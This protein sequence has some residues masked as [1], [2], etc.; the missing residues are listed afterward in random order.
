MGDVLGGGGETETERKRE[1]NPYGETEKERM[2]MK[3]QKDHKT[4]QLLCGVFIQR[5]WKSPPKG[6]SVSLCSCN[7]FHDSQGTGGTQGSTDGRAV[8]D[9]TYTQRSSIQP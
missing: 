7:S 6:M 4:Q 3:T 5:K 8:K 9:A 2:R 1:R